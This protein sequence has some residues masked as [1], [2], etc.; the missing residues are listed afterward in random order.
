MK[1]NKSKF[2][3]KTTSKKKKVF[4][5]KVLEIDPSNTWVGEINEIWK[6][7]A[8]F[9]TLHFNKPDAICLSHLS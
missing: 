1:E 3:I 9:E 2:K 6:S 5:V 7:T 8:D 4:E